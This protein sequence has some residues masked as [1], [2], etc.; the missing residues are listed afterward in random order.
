VGDEVGGSYKE[1]DGKLNALSL[2][3]GPV[4]EGEKKKKKKE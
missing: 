4:P 1:V 2:R 3:I